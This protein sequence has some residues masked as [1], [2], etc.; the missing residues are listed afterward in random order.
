MELPKNQLPNHLSQVHEGEKCNP[1]HLCSK[2]FN[3]EGS[4]RQHTTKAHS[5]SKSYK[6]QYC[7]KIYAYSQR[8]KTHIK[9]VHLVM[10]EIGDHQNKEVENSR[11]KEKLSTTTI[12]DD[13]PLIQKETDVHEGKK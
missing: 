5:G 9:S 8:L 1:C 10:K 13:I 11:M 7:Q 12:L 3:S 6:C 2:S 4:L